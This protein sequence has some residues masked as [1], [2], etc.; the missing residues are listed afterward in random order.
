MQKVT[1]LNTT[2]A[3]AVERMNWSRNFTF[4]LLESFSD[5]QLAHRV[6]GVGNH[7]LWIMGHIAWMDD[8]S[9]STVTGEPCI[10]PEQYTTM[11]G[12]G[13]PLTGNPADYPS[14]SELVAMMTSARQRM[15]S[16]AETLDESTSLTPTPESLQMFSP[17]NIAL[18]FTIVAHD[19]FHLGQLATVR[20]SL[21]MKL[22]HA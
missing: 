18:P 2:V 15:I 22:V 1:E 12:S 7:A 10:L 21:G 19:L 3:L 11:F 17:N 13:T 8:Y 20:S 14:Q 6:D 9:V 16:W 5:N 4:F